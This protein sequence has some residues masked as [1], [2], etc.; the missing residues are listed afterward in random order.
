MTFASCRWSD[1]EKKIKKNENI[2]EAA[3]HLLFLGGGGESSLV[4][5]YVKV[6]IYGIDYGTSPDSFLYF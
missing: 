2:S 3:M 1:Y 4:N 5:C 6:L